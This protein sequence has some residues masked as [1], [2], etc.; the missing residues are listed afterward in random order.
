MSHLCKR[1]N[2][3]PPLMST[4][5]E[6]SFAG[7]YQR[8]NKAKTKALPGM[9]NMRC[10]PS[11][12]SVGH[13][14]HGFCGSTVAFTTSQPNPS[15]LRAWAQFELVDASAMCAIGDKMALRKITDEL[16]RTRTARTKPWLPAQQTSE[17]R[18]VLNQERLGYNYGWVSNVHSCHFKHCLVVYLFREEGELGMLELIDMVKSTEFAIVCSRSSARQSPK[19]TKL[20]LESGTPPPSTAP[21]PAVSPSVPPPPLA[22]AIPKRAKLLSMDENLQR[23]AESLL[24]LAN[25]RYDH[26]FV[27]LA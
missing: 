18:F 1:G 14:E 8:N 21:Q 11:H 27:L 24:M 7:I 26:G 3:L 15:T 5:F 10:F 12:S 4:W 6:T 16:E 19:S 23:T 22:A 17:G 13:V 9:K 20:Q 25:S 2:T